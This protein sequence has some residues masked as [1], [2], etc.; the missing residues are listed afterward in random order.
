VGLF[1][2][3]KA[4]TA[5]L[6]AAQATAEGRTVLLYRYNI[7]PG[8]GHGSGPISGAAKVIE[9]AERQGWELGQMAYDRAGSSHGAVLLLF[10]RPPAAAP[11]GYDGY[12]EG[13]GRHR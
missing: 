8:S 4:G 1:K 11:A 6:H 10:R 9:A 3:T 7:P 2:E 13:A 12:T 5:E